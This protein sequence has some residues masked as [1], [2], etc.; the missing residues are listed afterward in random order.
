MKVS[1]R[2]GRSEEEEVGRAVDLYYS[3]RY[4]KAAGP[5]RA[6]GTYQSSG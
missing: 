2:P 6:D 5:L 4:G 3:C 1:L